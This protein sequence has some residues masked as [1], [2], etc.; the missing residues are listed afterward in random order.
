M[1]M[2][3]DQ[4]KTRLILLEG[5][6]GSGKSTAGV[7]LQSHLEKAGIPVRFWREGDFDNPADFEGVACL[8]PAQYRN[9]IAR[10]PEFGT[11][12]AEQLTVQGDDYLIKY[13]KLQSLYP[14]QIPSKLIL[15][16]SGY[17]VYDGLSLQDYCRLALQRWQ[18]FRTFTVQSNEI[19]ILECCFLQ[20]PQTQCG[21]STGM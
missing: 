13:R 8:N 20:N 4:P 10:H 6:P 2:N 9:L 21:Y 14:E 18:D 12:L 15:E 19:T 17:D 7:F 1:N 16:L 11:L 3:D 5:V